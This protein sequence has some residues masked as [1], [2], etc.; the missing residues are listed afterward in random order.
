MELNIKGQC[1]NYHEPINYNKLIDNA[2][3][4]ILRDNKKII[5]TIFALKEW[6]NWVNFT[7]S[8]VALYYGKETECTLTD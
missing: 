1:V 7:K 5:C 6:E 4:E 2:V 8:Q 3:L